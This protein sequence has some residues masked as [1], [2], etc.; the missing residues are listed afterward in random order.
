MM[1]PVSYCWLIMQDHWPILGNRQQIF[2]IRNTHSP[3]PV[4]IP[5]HPTSFTSAQ[6]T[7][8]LFVSYP[9]PLMHTQIMHPWPPFTYNS[10][11]S[12][13]HPHISIFIPIFPY[14]NFH[15]LH[16]APH[17]QF[18]F[19]HPTHFSHYPLTPLPSPPLHSSHYQTIFFPHY[20]IH[21]TSFHFLSYVSTLHARLF[22]ILTSSTFGGLTL[23]DE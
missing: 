4:F 22:S 6:L 12:Y 20:F 23:R 5:P 13:P 1:E 16:H 21:L 10:N 19:H 14:F 9:F 7:A 17:L 8:Q 3:K 18:S 2:L 11:P 15:T